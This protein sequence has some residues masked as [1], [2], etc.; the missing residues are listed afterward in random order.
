MAFFKMRISCLRLRLSAC[1][2]LTTWFATAPAQ[3]AISPVDLYRMGEGDANA[4]PGAVVA[5]HDSLRYYSLLTEGTAAPTYS[6]DVSS[7]AA[8]RTGSTSSVFLNGGYLRASSLRDVDHFGIETWVKPAGSPAVA[9][10]VSDGFAGT[11]TGW[12]LVQVGNTYQ[13]RIG[14]TYFGSAPVSLNSWTHLALVFDGGTATLYADGVAS[15]SSLATTVVA[16]DGYWSLGA[17]VSSGS[18]G[19]E[20]F[21][22]YLDEVR[23]FRFAAGAF[24]PDDLMRRAAN[25]TVEQ[26]AG[27][28]V[29][30]GGSRDFGTVGIGGASS[31]TFTVENSGVTPLTGIRVTIGSADPSQFQVTANPA[32]TVAVGASSTFTIAFN[33]L[34]EGRK[35]AVV[36]LS[37]NDP[38]TSPYDITVSG[39][40]PAPEILVEQPAGT[41]LFTS[42]VTWLGSNSLGEDA[43][44]AGLSN[45]R[46][47]A[48]G[49]GHVLALKGD[50]TVSGWGLNNFGQTEIPQG[51]SGV[52]AIAA[53]FYH[54]VVVKTDG[55]VTGWG[56]NFYGQCTPPAGLSGVTAISAGHAFTMALK[57]DGS[58]VAWGDNQ[59]GD[60]TVPTGLTGVTAIAA[61]DYHGLALKSDGTVVAWGW[62]Q[63]GQATVPAGL[64]GVVAL[65]AGADTSWALKGDGTVVKWGNANVQFTYGSVVTGV[66]AVSSSSENVAALKSDGAI[67]GSSYYQVPVGVAGIGSIAADS[68]GVGFVAD[69]V[70]NFGT[71]VTGVATATKTFTVRNSG[72][73]PLHLSSIAIAGTNASDFSLDRGGVPS[74]LAT[75]MTATFTVTFNPTT[76]LARVAKLQV[77]SDDPQS[78]GFSATLFGRGVPPTPEISIFAGAVSDGNELTDAGSTQ[79]FGPAL[80]GSATIT[81]TFTIHNTG[82]ASLSPISTNVANT[83]LG[84]TFSVSAPA[85]TS[86]APGETTTFTVSYSPALAGV[87]SGVIHVLSNDSD[88]S[89]F[90]IPVS[91]TAL[92]PSIEVLSQ[93]GSILPGGTVSDSATTASALP[94]G[95]Q[96]IVQLSTQGYQ[97]LALRNDGVVVGWNEPSGIPLTLPVNLQNVVSVSAGADGHFLAALKDGS[98]IAWGADSSGDTEVPSGL[99]GVVQVATGYGCS[100][101]LKSDGTVVAWGDDSA[102]QTEVPAGL[103]EVKAISVNNVLCLALKSDGTVVAWGTPVA[104]LNIPPGLADVVAIATGNRRALALKSDGTV[105]DLESPRGVPEGLRGVISIGS[106]EDIGAA[107]TSDGK[108]VEWDTNGTIQAIIPAPGAR[109]IAGSY[110]ATL[111]IVDPVMAF[112][113]QAAHVT[114]ASKTF[115]IQNTGPEPLHLTGVSVT[116]ANAADFSLTGGTALTLPPLT[117]SASL[118]VKFTPSAVGARS[119]WVKVFS[120]D[121][122]EPV[123]TLSLQGSG[124]M[125]APGIAVEEPAGSEL[126]KDKVVAWG[127]ESA[128]QPL[129]GLANVKA[130]SAGNGTTA[131]VYSDGSVAAWDYFKGVNPGLLPYDSKNVVSLSIG[132]EYVL[133]KGDGTVIGNAPAGLSG[134]IKVQSADDHRLALKS[135]GTV[136]AWG[137]EPSLMAGVPDGLTGVTDIATGSGFNAAL[138]NDGT[139]VVWGDY[140]QVLAPP[141]EVA[142]VV[143]IAGGGFHLL[144]L[145]G[146]GTVVAWGFDQFGDTDVPSD[147]SDVVDISAEGSYSLALKADGT[148]V[149]WGLDS[150]GI[151]AVP[152]GLTGVRSISAGP[153][154]VVAVVNPVVPFDPAKI[155]SSSGVK[156]F[157]VSN[158][159]ELPLH[160]LDINVSGADRN[161]FN[162]DTTGML[163]TVPAYGGT[164]TFK[165][166]FTPGAAGDR[167]GDLHVLSDSAEDPSYDI[168]LTGTGTT[169]VLEAWRLQNFGSSLDAG[170]AADTADPN[171]NGVGN[172]L[173]YALDGHP[174]DS[175]EGTEILPKCAITAGGLFQY[176][177]VRNQTHTG[178]TMTVQGSNS[179]SGAWTDLARSVDGAAFVSLVTG[180][181][182]NES[183]GDSKQVSLT[184]SVAPQSGNAPAHFLRLAVSTTDP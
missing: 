98:V 65:A 57:Q 143:K 81:R 73:Q 55:T 30:P 33:P 119:A 25:A 109:S 166:G 151:Y 172:L 15:G 128:I 148:V 130:I 134:V 147:L 138:K 100:L 10:I 43:I 60:T 164:V 1:L 122:N 9:S 72:N 45:V 91:G 93:D 71:P 155:G 14:T 142:G 121:Q 144:G 117:G 111:S 157:T 50:G 149:E 85:S 39:S 160:I 181:T 175:T 54:S 156:S 182:V 136:V 69:G 105:I 8:A 77:I 126:I 159:G 75:G 4:M 169:T 19:M 51:L 26:P 38:D 135:D 184:E 140:G 22:G 49:S 101:A 146:D 68:H 74:V 153:S 64:K 53:G 118:T 131:V 133:L 82:T 96:G 12:A 83:S 110:E 125:P 152:T 78:G 170:S 154:H 180:V 102:H 2:F 41:P 48:A 116:G 46:Q 84:A 79:S 161:D 132:G 112:D 113:R 23:Y 70:V 36:H 52:K 7:E 5:T 44:P 76:T 56:Y 108:L 86:L 115:T 97:T 42:G 129:S 62:N 6:S 24:N 163:T 183:G 90:D 16:P 35:T 158:P 40:T 88:E 21:S 63:Y 17:S 94:A 174:V 104:P 32:P 139:V 20:L 99:T 162:V 167:Y 27:S 178:I 168:H 177:F 29:A 31:L 137:D 80:L 150:S 176:S 145:K 107:L 171:Q 120:D 61:G 179:L 87:Q 141:P 165:V 173:E 95:L 59:R 34:T 103:T 124:F 47:L 3:A 114:S 127:A 58:V 123:Y 66:L 28:P 18:A 11:A 89:S 37:S 92:A 13:G 67:I 106:W